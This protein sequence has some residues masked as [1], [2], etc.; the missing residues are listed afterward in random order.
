M[1]SS[2]KSVK[3]VIVEEHLLVRDGL[4]QLLLNSSNYRI[5][6]EA[7]ESTKAIQLIK[8]KSPDVVLLDIAL[9]PLNGFEICKIIKR[10][11]RQVKVLFVTISNDIYSVKKAIHMGANGFIDKF[12]LASELLRSIDLV[13]KGEFYLSEAISNSEL[14]TSNDWVELITYRELEILKNISNGLTSKEIAENLFLAKSTVETHR[15]NIIRKLK[16]TNTANL[17]KKAFQLNLIPL[18]VVD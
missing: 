14:Y 18:N 17:I 2:N 8:D 6:G 5:V 4:K 13:A 7:S 12:S 3:I 15:K 11:Y 1:D 10:E 16:A 9:H